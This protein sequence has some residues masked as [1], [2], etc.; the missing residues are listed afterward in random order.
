M[1]DVVVRFSSGVSISI[2]L[3]EDVRKITRVSNNEPIVTFLI[4]KFILMFN[5]VVLLFLQSMLAAKRVIR[6]RN[7]EGFAVAISRLRVTKM[8]CFLHTVR[9]KEISSFLQR[10]PWHR[11]T[12]CFCI[13]SSF[14]P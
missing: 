1:R 7:G 5:A 2:K 10:M 11:K 6:L 13:F 8:A 14:T 4:E 3:A 9:M 12:D